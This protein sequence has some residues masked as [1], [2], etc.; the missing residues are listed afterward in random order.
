MVTRSWMHD[1]DAVTID[2]QDGTPTP[3][4]A[5]VRKTLRQSVALAGKGGAQVFVRVNSCLRLRRQ[6]RLG[7]S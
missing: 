2:L 3:E 7:V 1:A 5:Q 4:L 6:R